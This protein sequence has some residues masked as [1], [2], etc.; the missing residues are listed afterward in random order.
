[1]PG[2]K[3][4]YETFLITSDKNFRA[5]IFKLLN[6]LLF[7][8]FDVCYKSG[9]PEN[10]GDSQAVQIHKMYVY[11]PQSQQAISNLGNWHSRKLFLLNL[12]FLFG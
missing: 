5:R 11:K 7:S 8:P 4:I 2:Q 1:M 12:I 6:A 3:S 10:A 9:R